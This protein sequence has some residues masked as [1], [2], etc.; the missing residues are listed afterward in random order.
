MRG[1]GKEAA[2]VAPADSYRGDGRAGC[3]KRLR[4][5]A[6]DDDD[7]LRRLMTMMISCVDR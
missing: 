3:E 6:D 2:G 1:F 5:Q 4:I 7:N